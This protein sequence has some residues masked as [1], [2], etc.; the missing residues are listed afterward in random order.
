LCGDCAV[1]LHCESREAVTR[2][3]LCEECHADSLVRKLYR[4]SH[5]WS[6]EWEL[7]LRR[8]TAEVQRELGRQR[9]RKEA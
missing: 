4:R 9:R 6:P 1:C 5:H 2:L 8:K 7:H 3:G